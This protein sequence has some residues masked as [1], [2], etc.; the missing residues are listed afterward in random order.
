LG[1]TSWK[2]RTAALCMTLLV[3]LAG[4]ACSSTDSG[5]SSPKGGHGAKIPASAFGDRTGLTATTVRIGNVST[6]AF[7]GLFKGAV[8]GTQ[9]YAKFVNSTRGINGRKLVVDSGDDGFSGAGNKQ[10]TQSSIARDFALVGSFSLQDN[11]G[12]Q[13]LAKP[14]NAGVPDVSVTLDQATSALPNV[15]SPVPVSDGWELGPL[16]Y[17]KQ[18]FP[19]EVR[20]VGALVANQPSAET[21]WKGEKG[22][23]KHVG[24]KVVYDQTFPISQ[25]TFSQNVIAMKNKHVKILFIEQMPEIYASAVISAL[26]DQ[27]FHPQV[28]FGASTYSSSLIS[29]SGGAS[30]TDGDFLEQNTSLYLG[31]DQAVIPAVSTFL[32]W[33]Q[34]TSPGFK[35]DLFTLYGWLSAE[36]F[37]QALQSAGN[38]PSR[39]SVLQALS[40]VTS[41][42][43]G[44]I[45]AP[46]DPSAKTVGTCYL[47]AKVV[48]G[49]FQRM[50][51]SAPT[52]ST[53]GYRC[54]GSYYRPSHP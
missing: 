45:I 19:A 12:G 15:F 34:A 42:D 9:A 48:N 52:G 2:M 13:L 49:Q 11:F 6:L 40:K 14:K 17:Y 33:V 29:S 25:T 26:N 10:Y 24:Y 30:A 3:G 32:Q 28:V 4:A 47:L 5:G 7:G 35:P 36:L 22:A 51:D 1:T 8:I 54:D 44:H 53:G 23:M 21:Q 41:F 50:D 16:N 43:G 39:G 46:T 18:K 38:N 37:S 27:N 20:A 31:E